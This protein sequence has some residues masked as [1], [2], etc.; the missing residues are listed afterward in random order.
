MINEKTL[1]ISILTLILCSMLV[2]GQSNDDSLTVRTINKTNTTNPKY[3]NLTY[4]MVWD[5]GTSVEMI[6]QVFN[7]EDKLYSP[8]EILFETTKGILLNSTVDTEENAKIITFIV[9]KSIMLGS[10]SIEIIIKDDR[11]LKEN[12]E[13]KIGDSADVIT[14]KDDYKELMKIMMIFIVI[15]IIGLISIVVALAIE[16][17]KI[18]KSQN[19]RNI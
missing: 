7:Q 15:V 6:V 8:R 2:I 14:E 11:I 13:F 5:R 4:P 9:S 12:I 17:H 10:N 3:I 1:F 18:T 16:G 19:N